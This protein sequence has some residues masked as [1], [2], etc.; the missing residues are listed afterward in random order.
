MNTKKPLFLFLALVL[1]TLTLPAALPWADVEPAEDGSYDIPW[2]GKIAEIA[3]N[4]W[5]RHEQLGWIYVDGKS[6]QSVTIYKPEA[7]WFWTGKGSTHYFYSYNTQGW[8][9][10]F[11]GTSEPQWFYDYK[12]MTYVRNVMNGAGTEDLSPVI[13][14]VVQQTGVPAMACAVVV[15]GKIV[16]RGEAGVIRNGSTTQVNAQS[17]WVIGSI[18][19]SM[20]SLLVQKLVDENIVSWNDRLADALPD[21]RMNPEWADV[22]LE[23]LAKHT[24][25]IDDAEILKTFDFSKLTFSTFIGMR[26]QAAS[27]IL[28]STKPSWTPGTHYCYSSIGYILLA[29]AIEHETGLATEDMLN[30]MVLAPLGFSSAGFRNPA[31][32]NN[33]DSQPWGHFDGTPLDPNL[34]T[35]GIP[36]AA[37]PAGG[38]NMTID[39]L[40]LYASAHLAGQEGLCT[41][42]PRDEWGSL[43]YNGSTANPDYAFGWDIGNYAK[44]FGP[45]EFDHTGCE[46]TFT[47]AAVASPSYD[48]CLVVATNEGDE[49]VSEPALE[50][51]VSALLN[52]FGL[53]ATIVQ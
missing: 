19:K 20:T 9:Y 23:Q 24:A 53:D 46:K 7:G 51:L 35:T 5:V 47:A 17:K 4:G 32:G 30:N 40:A 13:A 39:D 12:H 49:T 48:L 28:Q 26:T 29:A 1:S 21:I 8:L 34:T 31:A 38:V 18:T 52:H 16:A 36:L 22:T 11:P 14:A 27:V 45:G 50:V 3:S 42:L 15:K 25:G 2:L 43:H 10:Y 44:I 37:I 6:A 41:Y 33:R